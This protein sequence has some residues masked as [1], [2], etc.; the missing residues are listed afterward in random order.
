MYVFKINFS[1]ISEVELMLPICKL[2]NP[3]SGLY[4]VCKYISDKL[5]NKKQSFLIIK[6]L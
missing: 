5:E 1:S 2:Y 4:Y 6:F 3:R